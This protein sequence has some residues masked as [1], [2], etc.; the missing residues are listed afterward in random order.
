MLSDNGFLESRLTSLDEPFPDHEQNYTTDYD[1]L[2]DSDLDDDE[3]DEFIRAES[4]PL[5]PVSLSDH[6][7]GK[8]EEDM[9]CSD[10][11]CE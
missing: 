1:Y 11:N 5:P 3:R 7:L 6:S 10:V 2:S 8:I 4:P 9:T